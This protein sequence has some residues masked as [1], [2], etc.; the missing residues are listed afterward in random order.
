MIFYSNQLTND[1]YCRKMFRGSPTNGTGG[2]PASRSSISCESDEM[3]NDQISLE[4]DVQHL[5]Q[6]V[7]DAKILYYKIL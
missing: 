7:I 5:S 6:K 4:E 1:F 3:T 2:S